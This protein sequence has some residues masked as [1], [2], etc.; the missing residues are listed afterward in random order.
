MNRDAGTI[1]ATARRLRH[2]ARAVVNASKFAG[3]DPELLARHVSRLPGFV[4][5]FYLYRQL[6]KDASFAPKLSDIMPLLD[7][8]NGAAGYIGHYFHQDLWAARKV[9]ARRP[10][11]HVD[12]ASRI[13]GFVAHLL[14]FMPVEIVD[15][16]PID[17]GVKGLSFVQD[18]AT[19]LSLFAA[20]SV[21]SLS[22]LHAAEHFGLGRYSDPIDPGASVRFM[23]ALQR[24]LAPDGRLY[25]SVPIG[26]QRV[27]FNAHRIFDVRTILEVFRNLELVSFSFIGSDGYVHENASPQQTIGMEYACG[28]FEFS[29]SSMHPIAGDPHAAS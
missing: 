5:D 19:E 26:R 20:D 17:G 4:S 23:E 1:S 28:L 24:V 13:D 10:Q 22:S 15:I 14:V 11:K 29:K 21:D 8:A 9:Y 16:R 25:F 18:D 27:E 12:I 3:F 2:A 6:N 7:D